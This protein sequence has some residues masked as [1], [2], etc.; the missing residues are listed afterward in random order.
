MGQTDSTKKIWV[1]FFILLI[2][3]AVEVG[4]GM[5]NTANPGVI[6]WTLLKW[7]F[8]ILTIFKA[9]YIVSEFMHLGHE[10]KSLKLSLLLP[11]F[12]LVP[13]LIYIVLT[14]GTYIYNQ[15][16]GIAQ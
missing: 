11:I 1:V 16:H 2:V 10:T 14:E 12:I 8:I 13:Y 9:Y 15:M 5:Y 4:L 7:T 3:T 6:N